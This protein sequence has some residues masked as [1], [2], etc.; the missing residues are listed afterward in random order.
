MPT[1]FVAPRPDC[2]TSSF[3]RDSALLLLASML[4]LA[5]LASW[6]SADS[7]TIGFEPAT[8]TT[9]SIDG[10]DGWGGQTP[11][12]I[13][14]LNVTKVR[15][16]RDTNPSATVDNGTIVVVGD[17]LFN[18]SP[19]DT[20]DTASGITIRVQDSLGLDHSSAP[21]WLATEC[22]P[23][24]TNGKIRCFDTKRRLTAVFFHPVV[25]QPNLYKFTIRLKRRALT[26]P[27]QEPITVTLTHGDSV[28]RQGAI[29]DC[30]SNQLGILCREF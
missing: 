3:T 29:V 9:G 10:R 6:A 24:L 25:L 30:S 16:K 27:F 20:F 12:G 5:A 8:Y 21:S 26:G 19:G 7:R 13:A 18:Q 2:E 14:N 4:F 23:P 1:R 11:P 17:F 28:D 15:I 22:K